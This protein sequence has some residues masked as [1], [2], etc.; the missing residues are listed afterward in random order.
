MQSYRLELTEDMKDTDQNW[1]RTEIQRHLDPRGWRKLQG[2]LPLAGIIGIFVAL[3]ALAGAGW[4]YGLTRMGQEAAFQAHTTDSL[5]LVADRLTRIEGNLG[6]LQAQNT[7]TKYSTIPVKELKQHRDE[8]VGVKK[9]LASLPQDTPNFWPTSFKIINLLSQAQ[10][11]SVLETVGKKPIITIENVVAP[12]P[13]GP[14]VPPR[15]FIDENLLLKGVVANIIFHGSVIHFD[16]SVQLSND[17][18]VNCVFIFPPDAN[19]PK[20]LQQIGS[21]LLTADF[22]GEIAIIKGS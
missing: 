11:V 14:I 15:L 4:N 18:F 16:A 20:N 19:P 6:I 17:A 7:V 22:S 13:P 21:Q 9:S 8:L 1:V 3:L 5:K 2:Y 10:A 12:P